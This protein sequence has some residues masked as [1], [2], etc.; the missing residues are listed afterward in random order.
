MDAWKLIRIVAPICIG[1]NWMDRKL[2]ERVD[3]WKWIRISALIRLHKN[4]FKFIRQSI[5]NW[6]KILWELIEN[7]W[8]IIQD[9][10]AECVKINSDFGP[11]LHVWKLFVN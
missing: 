3:A 9:K 2:N 7:Y 8:K 10:F 1:A 4:Y 5:E 11:D 6:L